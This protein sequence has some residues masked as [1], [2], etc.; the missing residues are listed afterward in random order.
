MGLAP[1]ENAEIFPMVDKSGNL[2]RPSTA[3]SQASFS[4]KF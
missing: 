3:D 4:K 2:T 1:A